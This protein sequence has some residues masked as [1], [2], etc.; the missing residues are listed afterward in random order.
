MAVISGFRFVP[1]SRFDQ[2]A[3]KK[4]NARPAPM[5]YSNNGALVCH[6]G[7][8]LFELFETLKSMPEG[9]QRDR[10]IERTVNQMRICLKEFSP[11]S[12]DEEKVA[13]DLA[14]YTDG[15][16]QIDPNTLRFANVHHPK[17]QPEKKKKKK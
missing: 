14:Y 3:A 16:V 7:V 10:L 2:E 4:I 13:S 17:R 1:P 12:A 9:E 6:Y 5:S 15:A 8:L 11:G